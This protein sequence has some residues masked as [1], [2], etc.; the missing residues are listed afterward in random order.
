MDAN[1]SLILS[2][3]SAVALTQAVAIASTEN[4]TPRFVQIEAHNQVE[5]SQIANCGVSLEAFR[6][7]SVWGFATPN[8][9][10]CLSKQSIKVLGNF[11]L[12]V[13]RGGHES[14]F[15]F[16]SNDEKFHDHAE[17]A[18]ALRAIEAANPEIC[19]VSVIGKSLEGRE[20]LGIH[21]N[22]VKESLESGTSS[23]PGYI[24]MGNHH[25]R[26]HL[27]VEVPLLFAQYVAKNK[28]D[29]KIAELLQGRDLWIIPMINPDGAEFDTTG[30]N[31][32]MWRKNRR[33]NGDGTYGVD[34]NRNYGFKWGTGGSSSE[35]DSDTYMGPQPFSEPETQN[36]RDF[37]DT[38]LNAKVLLTVH[39][40][41]ELIL[42]PWG[43]KNEAISNQADRATYE[44]MAKTMA[45]W[46]HYKPEQSSGLYIASGDTTDW[47]YGTHGIFAFTFEL[48]PNSMWGG[49]F[50]PGQKVIDKVFN[51]NLKPMLY[52]WG[53]ADDP[54]RATSQNPTG[55]LK[56]Y[57][58]PSLIEGNF[59]ANSSKF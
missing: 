27:S 8:E 57:V 19:K 28:A 42:Y 34:L 3:F 16:P 11:D 38:H 45:Q 54:H 30:G 10:A 14:G 32:Q 44:A 51:D 56:S 5:R 58:Q 31:Y 18:T 7:D 33:N 52:M 40:F 43:H 21:F 50:Y 46:N 20:V 53:L 9:L 36:V 55:F 17:V 1:Q 23:K 41:S 12:A 49:G 29:P 35:T 6:S 59:W 39:T 47:A 13:G 24:I 37:V 4:T 15:G 25:A 48:S 22:T 26:E 2:L